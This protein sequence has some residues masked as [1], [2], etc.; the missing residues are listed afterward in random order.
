M[1]NDDKYPA[2]TNLTGYDQQQ[3]V[4]YPR[5]LDADA[6]GA[7][8]QE[9]TQNASRIGQGVRGRAICRAKWANGERFSPSSTRRR[10]PH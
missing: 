9:S 4:T 7:D 1:L 5:L 10:A 2:D 6:E 8:W 3:V